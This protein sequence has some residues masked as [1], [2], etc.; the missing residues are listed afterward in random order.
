MGCHKPPRGDRVPHSCNRSDVL[1]SGSTSVRR[2]RPSVAT[3]LTRR[4]RKPFPAFLTESLASSARTARSAVLF[5]DKFGDHLTTPTIRENSCVNL[6]LDAADL[7]PMTIHDLPQTAA[8]LAV[9]WGA[10]VK[11]VQRKLGHASAAMTL[12]TYSDLSD[13]DLDAVRASHA[14]TL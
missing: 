12:D 8:S 1:R 10:N 9:S 4:S 14:C 11:A 3:N 7:K 13:D 5:P 2:R 6:A